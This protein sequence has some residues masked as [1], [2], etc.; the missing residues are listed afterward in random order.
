MFRP[1]DMMKTFQAKATKS[2]AQF[3]DLFPV[4]PLFAE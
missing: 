1:H 4:K 3:D 2:Q